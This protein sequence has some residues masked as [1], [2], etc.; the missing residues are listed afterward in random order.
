MEPVR[1]ADDTFCI[2]VLGDFLGDRLQAEVTEVTWE[3]K[4][5]TPDTVLNLA[6]LRPHIRVA[7]G[8]EGETEGVEFDGLA[9]LD[10]RLLF[11]RLEAFAPFRE[12][13]E[14]AKIGPILSTP[15]S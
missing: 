3:P 9:A 10:P 4:R 12:A 5:V 8:D 11:Q 1:M 15:S 14:A 6:G 2:A 7:V 13:R